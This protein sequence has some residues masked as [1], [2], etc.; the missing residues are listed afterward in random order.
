M[1]EVH[2]WYPVADL[3]L[4]V[5]DG[6]ILW[7]KDAGKELVGIVERLEQIAGLV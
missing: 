1:A 4:W 5:D 2:K 7:N 3:C 6:A